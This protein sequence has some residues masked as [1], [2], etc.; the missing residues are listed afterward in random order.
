LQFGTQPVQ[1][2]EVIGRRFADRGIETAFALACRQHVPQAEAVRQQARQA[3]G[4]RQR[5]QVFADQGADQLPELVD[6]LVNLT[7]ITLIKVDGFDVKVY[8]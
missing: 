7:S 6:V 1:P 3:L 8:N 5:I 2:L 4:V